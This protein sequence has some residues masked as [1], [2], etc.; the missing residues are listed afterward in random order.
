[1]EEKLVVSFGAVMIGS[2]ILTIHCVGVYVFVYIIYVHKQVWY[3]CK[4]V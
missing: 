2:I 3:F 4:Y 1:M